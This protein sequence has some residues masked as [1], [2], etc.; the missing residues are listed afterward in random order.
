M[1]IYK[2]V[3]TTWFEDTIE[4]TKYVRL[5]QS[6][7]TGD[8][9]TFSE[10]FQKF[11]LS[12]FSFFDVSADE[13]EKIYHS[14]V[15]GVLI[16][17]KDRYDVKSNRES[18]LGR[19][20]VMLIPKNPQDLGIVL[21]FKTIGHLDK[22]DLESIATSALQQIEDRKYDVE[23][24]ERGVSRILHLGLAF[25]GKDVMIRSKAY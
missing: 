12:A 22:S 3:V 8:V 18:G 1:E 23:L 11:L 14:F 20:D 6:L 4:E 24:K 15:L 13:P 10:I 16:G 7:T 5:L 25:K 17:L 21:E 9:A 2:S 19:Y